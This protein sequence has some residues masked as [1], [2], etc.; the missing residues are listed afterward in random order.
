MPFEH[1]TT[2][3]CRA[4]GSEFYS[5][6]SGEFRT[7]KCWNPDG[8]GGCAIDETEHYCR[9]IGEDFQVKHLTEKGVYTEWESIA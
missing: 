7:C 1:K 4:C 2:M 6:Y 5:R 9:Y 8:T 3:R